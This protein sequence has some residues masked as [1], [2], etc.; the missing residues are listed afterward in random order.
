MYFRDG[1]ELFSGN[2]VRDPVRH[3]DRVR[4]DDDLVRVPFLREPGRQ[5][6]VDVLRDLFRLV[7][8]DHRQRQTTEPTVAGDLVLRLQPHDVDDR[9]VRELVVLLPGVPREPDTGI[10]TDGP[11]DRCQQG[12]R[13]LVGVARDQTVDAG[14]LQATR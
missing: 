7:Q 5:L 10:L 2:A 14:M 6:V 8:V 12:V 9:A 1:A 13:H 4:A 11:P 3:L